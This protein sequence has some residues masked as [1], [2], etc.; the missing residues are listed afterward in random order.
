MKSLFILSVTVNL[1]CFMISLR[2]FR[3]AEDIPS[4][5]APGT[6]VLVGMKICS[7]YRPH[8]FTVSYSSSEILVK[9]F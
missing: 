4:P 8:R 3:T 5:Y 2:Q 1:L 6:K 7:S 9:L